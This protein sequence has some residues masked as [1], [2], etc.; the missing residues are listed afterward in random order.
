MHVMQNPF[1]TLW[2]RQAGSIARWPSQAILAPPASPVHPKTQKPACAHTHMHKNRRTHTHT[3][4]RNRTHMPGCCTPVRQVLHAAVP[5]E[6]RGRCHCVGRAAALQGLLCARPGHGGAAGLPRA[7]GGRPDAAA[8]G[9][10]AH[11]PAPTASTPR[12]RI[13]R[14]HPLEPYAHPIPRLASTS[15]C[16]RRHTHPSGSR[17]QIRIPGD[18]HLAQARGRSSQHSHPS[19]LMRPRHPVAPP[20]APASCPRPAPVQASAALGAR[21][22]AKAAHSTRSS[23]AHSVLAEV[24]DKDHAAG[25]AYFARVWCTA[26]AVMA[27]LLCGCMR[28]SFTA[29]AWRT[30]VHGQTPPPNTQTHT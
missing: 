15:G 20:P 23:V 10:G 18:L 26:G 5:L 1:G 28:A 16:Q 12:G 17:I 6:Q 14:D 9:K 22:A 11:R 13:Q 29:Y 21:K 8:A 2:P 25:C 3:R 30:C 24:L 27:S 4:T 19:A 7:A